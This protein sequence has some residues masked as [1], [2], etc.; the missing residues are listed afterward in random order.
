MSRISNGRANK[1]GRKEPLVFSTIFAK[2]EVSFLLLF[3]NANDG[4]QGALKISA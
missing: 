3:L 2:V 4:K 1:E